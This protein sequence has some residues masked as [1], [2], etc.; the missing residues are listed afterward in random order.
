MKRN[1]QDERLRALRRLSEYESTLDT[2]LI[3]VEVEEPQFLGWELTIELGESGSRRRDAD[4]LNQALSLLRYNR[5]VYIKSESLLRMFRSQGY[6]YQRCLE[7]YKKRYHRKGWWIDEYSIDTYRFPLLTY[8]SVTVQV[9]EALPANIQCYFY[10]VNR[11]WWREEFVYRLDPAR[12][13]IYE[14]KLKAKQAYSTHRGIP[15][16]EN[17]SESEKIRDKLS[18]EKYWSI[19][20]QNSSSYHAWSAIRKHRKRWKQATNVL[21]K[22]LDFQQWNNDH[23]ELV[24]KQECKLA[25]RVRTP[26]D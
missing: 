19:I 26:W 9:W 17:E 12:F 10:R 22:E 20:D 2:N 3:W 23:Y 8:R 24:E 25:P 14:L 18:Q 4:D 16:S 5:P 7:A 13:P 1:K 6:D 21:S 11:S 15:Q